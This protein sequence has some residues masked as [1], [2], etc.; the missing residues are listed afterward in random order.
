M[1]GRSQLNARRKRFRNQLCTRLLV[2]G[3]TF[4]AVTTQ[5]KTKSMLRMALDMRRYSSNVDPSCL[6]DRHESN[7]HG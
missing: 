1:V 2:A 4:K 7:V 5:L 6:Y 3:A